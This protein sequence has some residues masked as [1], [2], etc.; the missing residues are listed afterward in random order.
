MAGR[1][2]ALGHGGSYHVWQT[3]VI[4]QKNAENGIVSI[5]GRR[6]SYR[7]AEV[8]E[9]GGRQERWCEGAGTVSFY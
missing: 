3:E 8:Y 7:S 4:L 2:D 5:K 1:R 9:H 6:I